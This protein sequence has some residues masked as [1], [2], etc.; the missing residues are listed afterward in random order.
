[1]GLRRIDILSRRTNISLETIAP[2][3]SN[4]WKIDSCF[5][6]RDSGREYNSGEYR[7]RFYRHTQIID[8][9][10]STPVENDNI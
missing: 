5:K 10:Q 6:K 9:S 4:F 7:F 8:F 3:N 2:D 1:M